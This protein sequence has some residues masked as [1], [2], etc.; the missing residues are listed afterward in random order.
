MIDGKYLNRI[1]VTDF[2][3]LAQVRTVRGL[4][5]DNRKSLPPFRFTITI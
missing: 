2:P 1:N 3:R 4:F 5:G